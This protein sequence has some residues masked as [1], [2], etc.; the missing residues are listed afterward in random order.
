MTDTKYAVLIISDIDN[1][2]SISDMFEQGEAYGLFDT[3]EEA[4]QW[5]SENAFDRDSYIYPIGV[6][7]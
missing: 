2:N 7:N 6:V 1:A 3:F 4:D 5:A